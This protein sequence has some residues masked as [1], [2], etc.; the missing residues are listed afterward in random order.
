VFKGWC[1]GA[2]AATRGMKGKESGKR[3]AWR[4]CRWSG[5]AGLLVA[6]DAR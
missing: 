2:R 1:G 6:E 3:G 5:Y 4:G